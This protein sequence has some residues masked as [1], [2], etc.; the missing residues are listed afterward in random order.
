MLRPRFFVLSFSA[1]LV[2]TLPAM[3]E[4][5]SWAR[6]N[7]VPVVVVTPTKSSRDINHVPYAVTVITRGDTQ[8]KQAQT[9]GDALSTVPNF[10]MAGG[11]IGVSEE[12]SLRGLSDRRMVIKIDGIRRNFRAQYAGRYFIDPMLVDRIEV[13]RGSNSSIDGSGAIAGTIQMFTTDAIKELRGAVKKWGAQMS[14]GF[15]SNNQ[16]IS[17][18]F[19][20]YALQGPV[21]LYAGGSYGSSGDFKDGNGNTVSP[22]GGEPRNAV[23]KAGY[24]F[25]PTHRAEIRVGRFYDVTQMP[26]TPFQPAS[27]IN[28]PVER[29]SAVTDYSFHY[30]LAP[31]DAAKRKYFDVTSVVYRSEYAISSRRLSDGRLD[32]TYFNTTGED[33]YNTMTLDAFGLQHKLTTGVEY[34]QND[35]AGL[36]NGVIRTLLGD[37]KDS[38]L[39]LYAQSET[40]LWDRLTLTPGIRFDSY[41]LKPGDSTL[42]SQSR[43]RWS[44]KIGADLRITDAFSVYGSVSTSFRTPTLTELYSTGTIFPGNTLIANPNLTPETGINKEVGMRYITS[45]A[46]AE[47]D[48]L[49]VKVSAFQNDI[50]DYIEQVI[51]ATTTQFLNVTQARLRGLELESDYRIQNYNFI[52]GAGMVR[53]YNETTGDNL[54]DVAADRVSLAAE[55]Y[56]MENRL[57][58]GARMT[59]YAPQDKIPTGQPLIVTTPGAVVYDL[60]GSWTPDPANEG[61]MRIDAGVDNVFDK[62]YR[63]QLAFVPEMGRN[64]KITLNW[65]F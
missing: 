60:Y 8:E 65:K 43:K 63:R 30:R 10:D 34:F 61:V 13:V 27:T 52:V 36:R 37:G 3:A 38:N 32:Q 5:P 12:P 35:Q 11:P 14:A 50:K 40:V 9:I 22:S 26:A 49:S 39:G 47:H 42:A 44:P 59:I 62:S 53:G 18:M 24:S 17:T 31:E 55:R 33:T 6:A 46:F 2:T 54:S 16:K 23:V 48:S 58:G 64:A 56:M 15:Q 19:N 28:A 29:G 1:M 21:D 41:E 57:K 25:S 4:V 51:G 7:N 20:T 45:D